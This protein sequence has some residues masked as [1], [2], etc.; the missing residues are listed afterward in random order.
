MAR[1][2]RPF[3]ATLPSEA[4][5]L[6]VLLDTLRADPTV[7][8]CPVTVWAPEGDRTQIAPTFNPSS[9]DVPAIRLNVEDY[10]TRWENVGQHEGRLRTDWE[11]WSAGTDHVER[12]CL[13]DVFRRA[14]FPQDLAA[15][16]ALDA[17]LNDIPGYFHRTLEQGGVQ[18][19]QLGGVENYATVCRATLRLTF[20]FDT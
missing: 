18:Q 17:A 15:S 5:I 10:A 4:R 6:T 16:Q 12:W 14:L 13:W 8:A 20:H 1:L 19:R 2:L 7:L 3:F 11:L 9:D